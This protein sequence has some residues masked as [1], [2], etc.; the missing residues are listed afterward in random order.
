VGDFRSFAASES[1][2][3]SPWNP[4]LEEVDQSISADELRRGWYDAASGDLRGF[5]NTD[6]PYVRKKGTPSHWCLLTTFDQARWVE[7]EKIDA[8]E[9]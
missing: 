7:P 6:G 9:W 8:L 3:L 5:V 2:K 1:W 4:N